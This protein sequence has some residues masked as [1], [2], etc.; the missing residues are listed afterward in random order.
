MKYSLPKL[1]CKNK[2]AFDWFPTRAQCFIY[3]NWGMVTPERMAEVLETTDDIIN[4]MAADMGLE[5]EPEVLPDWNTRGYITIIRN[6][7]HLLDYKQLCTLLGWDEEQ[8]AY[9]LKKD[10]KTKSFIS[11]NR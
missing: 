6:N 1:S 10:N 11:E 9:I 3:R 2:L 7:W 8:L 4:G 5:P